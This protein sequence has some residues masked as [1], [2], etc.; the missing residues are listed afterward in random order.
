M[1]RDH[2]TRTGPFSR[3][4]RYGQ[5]SEKRTLL[6][7]CRLTIGSYPDAAAGWFIPIS[8]YF[9][10]AK[11]LKGRRV[12]RE[13]SRGILGKESFPKTGW[14]GS[15]KN[16]VASVCPHH[17]LLST[18]SL[19]LLS[20]V[21]PILSLSLN[22]LLNLSLSTSSKPRLFL[23][24]C[25]S[26]VSTHS[27]L[28]KNNKRLSTYPLQTKLRI[29]S[30]QGQSQTEKE[31]NPCNAKM[32]MEGGCFPIPVKRSEHVTVTSKPVT[33]RSRPRSGHRTSDPKPRT[34]RIFYDD[35][36]A[37]DSS[38]DEEEPSHTHR[39][40]RRYVQEIRLEPK[41]PKKK[42]SASPEIVPKETPAKKRKAPVTTPAVDASGAPRFRG[43]R[44]RP[45][46]KYAA[47]IRDPLRRVRVWLGTFDTAEEAAK[48]YDSAAIKLRGPDATTNFANPLKKS[49]SSDNITCSSAG[50]ESTE[51]S[52][53][54]NMSS[55]KSV[56]RSNELPE[57]KLPE[58]QLLQQ[59]CTKP[60]TSSC[61][62]SAATEPQFQLPDDEPIFDDFGS[63]FGFGFG[64]GLDSFDVGSSSDP[65][66]FDDLEKTVGGWSEPWRKDLSIEGFGGG[67]AGE[68]T[69]QEEECFR[70]ITDLFPLEDIPA[71]Y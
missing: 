39:R 48:V 49:P 11:N 12:I 69:W 65:M 71:V 46:G 41:M 35:N 8:K 59:T 20:S 21:S 30:S 63:S 34:I 42:P 70:D 15:Y 25:L 10:Q 14:L 32:M 1:S 17:L 51:E 60:V 16:R 55:P 19:S 24:L 28:Y 18:E 23:L 50:Y 40:V 26:L 57:T 54:I 33:S 5:Q 3:C 4:N 66:F 13:T 53:N 62:I 2:T 29:S 43:V 56:L 7:S 44:R 64:F 52:Q 38:S 68:S 37:T 47:E 6:S 27:T 36:E 9:K 22:P 31:K 45:W 58:K 61:S 67:G